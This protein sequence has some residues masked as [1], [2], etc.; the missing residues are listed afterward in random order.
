MKNTEAKGRKK[1]R[2]PLRRKK[3]AKKKAKEVRYPPSELNNMFKL[4]R[5]TRGGKRKAGEERRGGELWAR[6]EV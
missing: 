6:G 2:R 3:A 1:R 4:T 5:R